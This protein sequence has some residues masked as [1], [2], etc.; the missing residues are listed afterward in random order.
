MSTLT[1]TSAGLAE[2]R[3]HLVGRSAETTDSGWKSLY[4]VGGA[5]ALLSAALIPIA[6]IV[7]FVSPPPSTVIDY[8]TLFQNSKLLGLLA[9]DLLLIVGN[10]LGVLLLLALYAVLRRANESLMAIA[11]ALGFVGAVAYFASNTAF[12]ML[13]LSDQYAA[14]TTEAQR[15]MFLAAGQAMLAIYNG[16]AFHVSY[17]ITAVAFLI[18]SVV[19]LRSNLFSKATAYIGIAAN[20]IALGL[21]LPTIGIYISIFSVVFLLIWYILIARRLFQLGQDISQEAT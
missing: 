6:I 18:I 14:A 13:S 16:T 15:A 2:S 9:M 3:Q 17:V 5:A 1:K 21:Y 19:M 4:K 12:N 10:V 11:L 7:Y 20:V 8:F